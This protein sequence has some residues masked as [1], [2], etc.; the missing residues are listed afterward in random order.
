MVIKGN[1]VINNKK[2]DEL[3]RYRNTELTYG[4]FNDLENETVTY[5]ITEL[6][7]TR[8]INGKILK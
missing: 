8:D 4:N 7:L 3:V 6:N 2:I 1:L 5:L